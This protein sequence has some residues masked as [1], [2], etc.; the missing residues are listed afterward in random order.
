M[1]IIPIILSGGSGTRLWPLSRRDF[2]KQYLPLLSDNSMLQE[3]ILRLD[4]VD[5]LLDPII[6]C[7]SAHRFIVAEQ[8]RQ[9]GIINPIILLE[10]IGRNTA[11]AIT[12]AAMVSLKKYDDSILLV[13]SAD[14][15]IQN[16]AA[17]HKALNIAKKQVINGNLATFGIFPTSANT[18]YGYI[19]KSREDSKGVFK[20]NDFIE[21]PDLNTAKL[22]IDSKDYFWNSG[23]FMFQAQSFLNE[24]SLYQ[25][26]II[27]FV[28]KSVSNSKKD[29]DFI[30]LEENAFKSAPSVSIDYA[31]ME[32]SQK[33]IVIQLDAGWNDIGSWQAIYDV[34]EKNSQGN[35]ITGDAI[36]HDT[37]NSLIKLNHHMVSV[38]GV[39]NL[40]IVDTPDVTFIS[41]RE[42]AHQV[43]S[44]VQSLG[45]IG[46]EVII[47]NR[48]VYRPW[49]WF[50]NIESGE[51]FQVKRLHIKSGAKLSLQLHLK[52]AE[53]WVVVKGQ[54]TVTID[55]KVFS[56]KKG[57][58]TY[59]PLGV[60]HA[61]ENETN[62]ILEIIEVQ[63]GAYLGEDDITRFEDIYGRLDD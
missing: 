54:A 37:K 3:T 49:G 29:L 18:E 56:L 46:S 52:R 62:D 32:K 5:N 35:V 34:S 11:P 43:K 17:F 47:S 21:K 41:S 40:V 26:E 39:E 45:E 36:V 4:G 53:H 15:L 27:E 58:S 59:I 51:F 20:V 31:L 24:L 33:L 50:D 63:S 19:K 30:R 16:L 55:E 44:I 60:K 14:H 6:V 48:K 28:S 9:I 23:I 10:P 42:K 57:E 7:N 61:L 1:K 8:C 22:F 12:A 13:L 2:P 38:L 25:P